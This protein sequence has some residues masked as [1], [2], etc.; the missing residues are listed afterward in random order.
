MAAK[1]PPPTPEVEAT[2][3]AYVRAG[4]Y[5]HVAVEAAGVPREVFEEWLRKGEAGRPPQ[6][7]AIRRG[8]AEGGGAGAAG[9]R[10]AGAQG[11]ADR[12]AQG[13]AGQGDAG[14]ARLVGAGQAARGA[15]KETPLLL[16]ADV[17]AF[18]RA[19]LE[20]LEPHPEARAAVAAVLN[21]LREKQGKK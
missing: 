18:L 1:H 16:R 8:A 12:L 14:P 10:D 2:I 3:V 7:Q 13:R 20:A 15:A 17:Q 21:G 5:L 19:V 9:R 4:G 11:Q 6:V